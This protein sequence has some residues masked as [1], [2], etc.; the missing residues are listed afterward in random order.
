MTEILNYIT[1]DYRALD[2]QETIFEAQDRLDEISFTHF[3]VVEEGVYI[4]C[5]IKDD[6]ETFDGQKSS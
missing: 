2:S 4:G 1:N 3:P 6:L 5:I